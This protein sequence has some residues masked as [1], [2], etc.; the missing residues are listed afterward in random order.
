MFSESIVTIIETIKKIP[1]AKTCLGFSR[2]KELPVIHAAQ[3][4]IHISHFRARL[5]GNLELGMEHMQQRKTTVA[6]QHRTK[7]AVIR[8]ESQTYQ[9][10][11]TQ[12]KFSIGIC[13]GNIPFRYF[14]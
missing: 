6:D 1:E 5:L 7:T 11:Q 4:L 10:R 3:E 8:P 12:S 14:L 13:Y 2:V 9:D